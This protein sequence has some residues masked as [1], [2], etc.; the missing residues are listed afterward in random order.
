MIQLEEKARC[1]GRQEIERERNRR[2]GRGLRGGRSLPSAGAVA[3]MGCRVGLGQVYLE[4]SCHSLIHHYPRKLKWEWILWGPWRST[5]E[6]QTIDVTASLE[7][8][9]N[10]ATCPNCF[11]WLFG[12]L[13]RFETVQD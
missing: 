1:E 4:V 9:G 8:N 7:H 12:F 5:V 3:V 2:Q 13:K 6:R 11:M 10:V